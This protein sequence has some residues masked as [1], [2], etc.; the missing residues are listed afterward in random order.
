MEVLSAI[1]LIGESNHAF[2]CPVFHNVKILECIAEKVRV[3]MVSHVAL[4][5]L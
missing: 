3:E 2:G 4:P 5:Q 1:F